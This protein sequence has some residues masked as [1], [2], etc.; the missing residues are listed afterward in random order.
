ML[1]K[2]FGRG[3]PIRNRAILVG[4]YQDKPAFE[5]QGEAPPDWLVKALKDKVIHVIDG[6]CH[7]RDE[8]LAEGSILHRKAVA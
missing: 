8:V 1:D 3:K 7:V 5:F 4:V 6:V 2:I